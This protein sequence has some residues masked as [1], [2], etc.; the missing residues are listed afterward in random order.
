[1]ERF[2][3]LFRRAEYGTFPG[4]HKAWGRGYIIV[5]GF[6]DVLSRLRQRLL[7]FLCFAISFVTFESSPTPKKK[8]KKRSILV[9][10]NEN[11]KSK[12]GK[13]V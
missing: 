5:R 3:F 13:E 1:M 9:T 2:V 8:K 11:K 10:C 6:L 4:E 12:S 7:W